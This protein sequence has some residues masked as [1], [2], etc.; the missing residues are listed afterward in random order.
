MACNPEVLKHVPLFALLDEEETAVLAGQ[1]RL[2][3]FSPRQRIYKIGDSS[4]QA[5]VVVSGRVR[6]S[7]V[8]QD[9]Q[10]VVID[11]PSHGEFFGF[12]SMLEQTPHQTQAEAIEQVECLEVNRNDI[13]VLLQRKPLAG[14]DM[15]TVLGRQFH[16][17]QQLV[18]LRANRHPNE[19]IEKDATVGEHVAD[20]VAGFGGSWTFIIL[21]SIILAIY[22]TLDAV[23]GKRAWDPYP[24]I[25]LNLFL[26]MLA[27]LQAPIIMMSQNRQDTKDR[28]RGELDYDVNRR[29]EVE[30]QGLARKLNLLGEKIGDVEEILREKLARG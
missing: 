24:Y 15:L 10:E 16:A 14:M 12:A 29:S 5:Y 26:N 27:A 28:L 3:T 22:M 6:V 21:F 18:R 9:Q 25:L 30:I 23:L 8:D 19:V 11:E 4:G 13:A 7:T 17:S 1:V 2:K 20:I